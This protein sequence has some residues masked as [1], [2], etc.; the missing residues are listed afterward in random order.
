MAGDNVVTGRLALGLVGMMLVAAL[1]ACQTSNTVPAYPP[2]F[3]NQAAGEAVDRVMGF[4]ARAVDEIAAYHLTPVDEAELRSIAAAYLIG[5]MERGEST[6][7]LIR[8]AVGAMMV[9]LGNQNDVLDFVQK[10]RSESGQPAG[11][12]LFEAQSPEGGRRVVA[13][14]PGGPL[15]ELGVRPGWQL[16]SIDGVPREAYDGFELFSRLRGAE[17][18]TVRLGFVDNRGRRQE[19]E[20]ARVAFSSM[21]P[22]VGICSRPAIVRIYSFNQPVVEHFDDFVAGC[23]AG[24]QVI[25]LRGNSGGTLASMEEA[26]GMFVGEA[27]IFALRTRGDLSV[28]Q[29]NGAVRRHQPPAVLLTDRYTAAAA[30][31]FADALR[32]NAGV[33]IAG[34]RTHGSNDI[35]TIEH[36]KD[37]LYMRLLTGRIEDP[38]TGR[39]L[40]P[41]TPDKVIVDD[42]ESDLDE[43]MLALPGLVELSEE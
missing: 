22:V 28:R 29:S 7:Q 20:V 32:R 3:R 23:P 15:F 21:P 1:S 25:D 37:G 30:E 18:S 5:G 40:G 2:A 24:A 34:E 14:H 8:G 13:V 16:T 26:V 35:H 4:V 33:L 39:P 11:V 36:I 9:S 6:D 10:H 41:L 43:V 19:F 31:V 17:G 38:D 12:G 42:P 27:P